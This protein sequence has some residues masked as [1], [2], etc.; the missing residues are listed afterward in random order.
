MP[1]IL[2]GCV[3]N[4][5]LH[6][7]AV[8]SMNLLTIPAAFPVLITAALL[9]NPVSAG[10]RLVNQCIQWPASL[11][12]PRLRTRASVVPST[13]CAPGMDLAAWEHWLDT[14]TST[15]RER[16][17]VRL[18]IV[19]PRSTVSQ[20]PLPRTSIGKGPSCDAPRARYEFEWVHGLMALFAK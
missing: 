5:V 9:S 7:T 12:N 16:G 8:V 18:L 15:T 4:C 2:K 20:R 11:F 17:A 14:H 6:Y 3:S 13:T 19:A 1:E 10:G